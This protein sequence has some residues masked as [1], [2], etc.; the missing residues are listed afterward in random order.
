MISY[1]PSAGKQCGA[2]LWATALVDHVHFRA[3]LDMP[4]EPPAMCSAVEFVICSAVCGLQG[5]SVGPRCEQLRFMF[6][7]GHE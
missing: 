2:Q 6:N 7:H 5:S 1:Q 3:C 4:L